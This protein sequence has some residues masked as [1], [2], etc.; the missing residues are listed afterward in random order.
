MTEEKT[1]IKGIGFCSIDSDGHTS[2]ID[3][4]DGRI[5]R[6]RPLHYDKKYKPD[7]FKPWKIEVRGKTLNRPLRR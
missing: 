3:V 4:K 7:E 6:I 5:I 1:L 2:E